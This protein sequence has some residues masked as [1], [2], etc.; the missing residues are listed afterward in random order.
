MA[1]IVTLRRFIYL[2]G[3]IKRKRFSV[4]VIVVGNLTVG[5]TGKTPLV[6]HLAKLLK[7]HGFHPGIVSRGYKR[8]TNDILF[9]SANSD[10]N[11]VGDEPL[12]LARRLFCPIV[13][14]SDRSRGVRAL[15]DPNQNPNSVDVVISDDGLQH[16][17]M[18]RTLE[19]LV[20]DGKRRFGNG[21]CL[22]AG[23]LREPISRAKKMDF[24]VVNG[25]GSTVLDDEVEMELRPRILYNGKN[26][27]EQKTLANFQGHRVHA[28]AGI[29]NPD[30]F[31]ALLRQYELKVTPHPFPD[32][33]RF[34][35]EDLQ[36]SDNYPILM[37]EK[38]AVKCLDWMSEK[39]WVL[40]VDAVV[41]PLFDAKLISR[42]KDFQRG[43]KS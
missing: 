14:S 2:S 27:S 16:Y 9:V 36:F 1:L 7:Q 10:P 28:V 29:G 24:R 4:P 19:I 6:I 11:F 15:L 12:L 41:N 3:V 40:S 21:W 35:P 34:V 8:K 31:F 30:Q 25:T 13:V 43:S 18:D 32:H 5:G 20:I 42:L 17:A 26:P 37:T 22:P 38:D 39:C 33:H 23:P